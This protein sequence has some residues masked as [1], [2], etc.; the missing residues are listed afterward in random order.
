MRQAA[1]YILLL[2]VQTTT[3]QNT[4]VTDRPDITE[5]AVTVGSGV[6]QLESGMGIDQLNTFNLAGTLFRLGVTDHWE[7]RAEFAPSLSVTNNQEQLQLEALELKIKTGLLEQAHYGIDLG[8]L[9]TIGLPFLVG[10]SFQTMHP[11]VSLQMLAARD[12]G[13][14]L[15]LGVNAGFSFSGE[16]QVHYPVSV[17]AGL[18][19]PC[20]LGLFL[21]SAVD[22]RSEG[23]PLQ[24]IIDGGMTWLVHDHLQLDISYGRDILTDYWFSGTGISWRIQTEK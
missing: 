5:S 16:V 12:L 4:I 13:N 2:L 7:F 9:C 24:H 14:Y 21:E 15:S 17:S 6:V 1:G 20:R 8:L 3:A 11:P 18:S 10:E 19:L 22:I 23:S